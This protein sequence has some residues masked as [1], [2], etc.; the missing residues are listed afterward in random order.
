MFLYLIVYLN[1]EWLKLLAIYKEAAQLG[2]RR[3]PEQTLHAF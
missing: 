1:D 2:S 3:I